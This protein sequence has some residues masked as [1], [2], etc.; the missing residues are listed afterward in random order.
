MPNVNMPESVSHSLE[1]I[2]PILLDLMGHPSLG[3]AAGALQEPGVPLRLLTSFSRGHELIC[4]IDH[5]LS[6]LG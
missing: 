6:L 3:A 5:S 4:R 1:I 2:A